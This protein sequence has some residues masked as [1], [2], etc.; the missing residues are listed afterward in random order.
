MRYKFISLLHEW[1]LEVSSPGLV[2]G[3]TIVKATDSLPSCSA[4]QSTG[5]LWYRV[6]AGAPAII[7]CFQ[8]N[9]GDRDEKE[10]CMISH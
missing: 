6:V 8:S 1:S 7:V 9:E 5:L 10:A 2:S 3:F 4:T